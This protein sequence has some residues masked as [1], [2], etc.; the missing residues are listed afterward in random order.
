[1]IES[2]LEEIPPTTITTDDRPTSLS[3][4]K[5]SERSL[6]DALSIVQLIVGRRRVSIQYADISDLAQVIALRLWK[7]LDKNSER[8]DSM[9][10][11][12]WSSYAARTAYNEVNRH[13]SRSA[14]TGFS[15]EVAEHFAGSS[16]EGDTETEVFSL[17]RSVWQEI[18]GL[19]LRQRRAL[20]LHS[21]ELVIY[22]LQSGIGSEELARILGF[23]ETEWNDIRLCIPLSDVQIAEVTKEPNENRIPAMIVGSIKKARHDARKRLEGI[24]RK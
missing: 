4:A 21:Q 8:S 19:S 2:L 12:E 5:N 18:C 17:I 9:S 13:L 23:G 7:W 22:F 1:M 20:L 10:D 6:L 3:A 11:E 24:R 16:V 15:I 14:R